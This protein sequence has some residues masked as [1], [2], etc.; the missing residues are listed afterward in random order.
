[1]NDYKKMTWYWLLVICLGLSFVSSFG[2]FKFTEFDWKYLIVVFVYIVSSEII[3]EFIDKIFVSTNVNVVEARKIKYKCYEIIDNNNAWE[4]LSLLCLYEEIIVSCINAYNI[5]Q[6]RI[7]KNNKNCRD[8]DLAFAMF[9]NKFIRKELDAR[10]LKNNKIGLKERIK[11]LRLQKKQNKE[12]YW[13]NE[14]LKYKTGGLVPSSL[15]KYLYNTASI[16][17]SIIPLCVTI[18]VTINIVPT[19]TFAFRLVFLGIIF[20]A[21]TVSLIMRIKADVK[22]EVKSIKYYNRIINDYVYTSNYSFLNSIA[23][24]R[25]YS[26][27]IPQETERRKYNLDGSLSEYRDAYYRKHAYVVDKKDY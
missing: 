4:K 17:L 6:K 12:S 9:R 3:F 25:F 20:M 14:Y 8:N 5:F 16:L 27:N 23:Y 24:F 10:Y 2:N 7:A 18:I 21:D 26:Y 11:I 19:E 15:N 1:M 22:Y 13:E